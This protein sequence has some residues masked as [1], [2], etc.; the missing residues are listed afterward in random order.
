MGVKLAS[1]TLTGVKS[2][3]VRTE[4]VAAASAG[5]VARLLS[6]SIGISYPSRWGATTGFHRAS[7]VVVNGEDQIT[8]AQVEAR[9]DE[10]LECWG[11]RPEPRHLVRKATFPDNEELFYRALQAVRF[12][13]DTE[14]AVRVWN[15]TN[16]A[17]LPP[18]GV[19]VHYLE[20]EV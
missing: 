8:V 19:T 6:A 17:S 4:T 15:A 5:T 7:L 14:L 11:G 12:D 16:A 9:Y 18:V 2:G 10:Y 13:E 20:T 1:L 3:E